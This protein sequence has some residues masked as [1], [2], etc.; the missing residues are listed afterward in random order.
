MGL[1]DDE[2]LELDEFLLEFEAQNDVLLVDEAHGFITALCVSHVSLDDHS[3]MRDVIGE[4]SFKSDAQKQRIID[5]LSRMRE[6]ISQGL[7][8]KKPFEPLVAEVEDEEGYLYE[9][10]EGWC[11]GFMLGVSQEEARWEDLPNNEQALL[12]PIARLALL[13][14]EEEFELDD[15]EYEQ[16]VELIPGSVAGLYQFFTAS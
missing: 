2:I 8:D 3:W 10:N 4:A 9:A 16:L 14:S 7:S 1:T 11:Y 5:L 12:M 15:E 6:E 13:Q